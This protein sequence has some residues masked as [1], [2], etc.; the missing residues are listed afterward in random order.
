LRSDDGNLFVFD[1]G[2]GIRQ[3][4]LSLLGD[5]PAPQRI[6]ILI[7]HTHWDHIQGFPFFTPVFL[8]GTEINIYAPVGFQRS[9]EEAMLGQM[10]YS[11]FPVKLED[12]SSR[13]H[14]TELEEGFFRIGDC[15]VETQYL[16]HT[17][18]TIAYRLTEGNTSVA[19]VTDHEPFWK[20]SGKEFEHPGDQRHI[21]FMR[22][23]DLVIHDAQY[24]EEEYQ[25]K[26]GWGH[27]PVSYVMDVAVAADVRRLGLFH[28]DPTHDDEWIDAMEN[29]FRAGLAARNSPMEVFAAAEGLEM[30]FEGQGPREAV[31]G[32]SALH[33]RSILGGRVLVISS[34]ETDFTLI[35]HMLIEDGLILMPISDPAIAGRR[36]REFSP[37]LV[38]LDAAWNILDG[39]VLVDDLREAT[40]MAGLPI[41]L[42]TDDRH[43][44]PDSEA[45]R[46]DTTDYL[47]RPFSP[48][49]LR[50]R[51]RAWLA[52][53]LPTS[54]QSQPARTNPVEADEPLDQEI[55]PTDPRYAE[56]LA[57]TKL[58]RHLD[59]N[60]L[61]DLVATASEQ[62]FPPGFSILREGET[63]TNVY[64]VLTGRVRVMETVP[65][66][67][68]D[69]F[70][71]EM[72]AGELF[73]EIGF[74]RETPRSATVLTLERTRCL[75]LSQEE[76]L[77]TLHSSTALCIALLRVMAGRLSDADRLLARY[78]PDP[79][80]GL[81]G[82]RA[83][84]DLYFR[85]AA[86]ARR[87]DNSVI[88]ILMDV[89]N[90]RSI[91][92]EFGYGVGDDVLKTMAE[93]LLESSRA[94]DLVAR[95][96]SDEFAILLI[97]AGPSDREMI[98]ERV[99]EK[100]S[101]LVTRRALPV[102]V[103]YDIGMAVAGEAPESV[104]VLLRSA[105]NE[106]QKMKKSKA[107][108]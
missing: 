76:F 91:N 79:L 78:A 20:S 12:L 10:Q 59:T 40:G 72:G 2:T 105:D 25:T 38:I 6:H 93:S 88:L 80:T 64:I 50:S 100:L 61:R 32:D 97:D 94:T 16:N 56:S 45:D 103:R 4:G 67:P 96:G 17:A 90:L 27:S 11:Y 65:D 14:Y 82:R 86:G 71:G 98:V 99:N 33:Q 8:P 30:E 51:V 41:V 75:V 31:A 108:G 69:M 102:A 70:L 106:T 39:R 53:T 29:E 44:I 104:E 19:Y 52:R 15:L 73:G 55:D 3:L 85:L 68:N 48:P 28:H 92:D 62:V 49:M 36:A 43:E 54:P 83:F 60:K 57:R 101:Q 1:C 47:E 77:D 74:L 22:D 66:G 35:E 13:I 37:D 58:F 63:G 84:H 87:R 89:K 46:G 23:A 81:P 7:G 42:L 95:F 24:S 5:S 9:L 26:V 107:T 21:E 34:H 18:P